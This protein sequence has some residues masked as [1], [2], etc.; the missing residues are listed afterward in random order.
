MSVTGAKITWVFMLFGVS[1]LVCYG[2]DQDWFPKESGRPI[3]IAVIVYWAAGIPLMFWHLG[4]DKE[5]KLFCEF[6]EKTKKYIKE[7]TAQDPK[8]PSEEICDKAGAQATIEMITKYGLSFRKMSRIIRL[9][10]R[11]HLSDFG[12]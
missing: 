12:K 3:A 6:E 1:F 2:L 9:G 10:R 5:R 11:L 7:Y 8:A 4:S